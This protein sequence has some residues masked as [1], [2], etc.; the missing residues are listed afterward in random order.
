VP[1]IIKPAIIAFINRLMNIEININIA[2]TALR[3]METKTI[4]SSRK[5][6]IS[7]HPPY[8]TGKN[9]PCSF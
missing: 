8:Y 3:A 6:I 2:V 9:S 7:P 1:Y 5:L 4:G